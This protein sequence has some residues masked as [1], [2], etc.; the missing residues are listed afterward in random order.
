[1]SCASGVSG[2]GALGVGGFSLLFIFPSM[3]CS[4]DACL[5][6]ECARSLARLV[7]W[8][9]FSSLLFSTPSLRTPLL[10]ISFMLSPF[11]FSFSSS[12]PAIQS[13]CKEARKQ[14][15]SRNHVITSKPHQ[16]VYQP[17]SLFSL[18][19]FAPL[20]CSLG[21]DFDHPSPLAVVPLVPDDAECMLA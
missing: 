8:H 11:F 7:L 19:L 9:P 13:V 14:A 20:L 2:R 21:L 16:S 12:V 4:M 10:V 17:T 5:V 1:M 18:A 3:P 15:S 6:L